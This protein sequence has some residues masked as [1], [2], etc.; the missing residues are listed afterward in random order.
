MS[1]NDT[2]N[3]ITERIEQIDSSLDG[4]ETAQAVVEVEGPLLTLLEAR[5]SGLEQ[6]R[7]YLKAN[8]G[9]NYDPE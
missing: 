1:Q 2:S 9:E 4:L 5:Q 7:D 8:S 3:P 6:E